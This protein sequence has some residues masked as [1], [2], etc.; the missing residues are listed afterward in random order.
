MFLIYIGAS[1]VPIVQPLTI[2]GKPHLPFQLQ[3]EYTA[4]DGSRNRRVIT[5]AKPTTKE[6]EVAERGM[7]NLNVA[8]C[9]YCGTLLN[10]FSLDIHLAVV[11]THAAHT[12]AKLAIE[13]EYTEAR[14]NCFSKQRLLQRTRYNVNHS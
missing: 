9:E 3:I 13:G 10:G 2:D 1:S 5:D 12:S 7:H 14:V 11:G 6:R 4:Q 8:V